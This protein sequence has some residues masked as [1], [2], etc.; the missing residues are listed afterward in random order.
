[1]AVS[2]AS[3]RCSMGDRKMVR[4][5]V[6]APTCDWPIESGR[7]H[8][9]AVAHLVRPA[10]GIETFES[11]LDA[12]TSFDA[13]VDHEL[14]LIFKGFADDGRELANYRELIGDMPHH[15]IHFPD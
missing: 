14:I 12:Y 3:W 15:E 13:G 5:P 9:I 2:R 10:H 7:M 11:F 6:F 4:H 1:M 8:D